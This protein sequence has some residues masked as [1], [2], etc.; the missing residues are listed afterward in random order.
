[1]L[2]AWCGNAQNASD[3]LQELFRRLA[4]SPS[5]MTRM[6]NAR[7]FLAVAARRIAVDFARRTATR[8]AYHAVAGA[9]TAADENPGPTD[10]AL[11]TAI[12][13]ALDN[14]PPEQRRVFQL[15]ILQGK[16]LEEIALLEKISLNTAASR[17]RY[18]LDKIRGPL[19]PY[20]DDLNRKD[21][22][23]MKN[24]PA[25]TEDIASQRIIT[26]LAPKRVPSV[27]PGLEG[28][29][30]MAPDACE[31]SPEIAVSEPEFVEASPAVE[32]VEPEIANCGVGGN[33]WEQAVPEVVELPAIDGEGSQSEAAE[34]SGE[35]FVTEEIPEMISCE[36]LPEGGIPEGWLR[37]ILVVES[38]EDL[39]TTLFE[40]ES[41]SGTEDGA[42]LAGEG[43]PVG[44]EAIPY[45]LESGFEICVL[46][47]PEDFSAKFDPNEVL[48]RYEEFLS[49]DP[50][51]L[52]GLAEGQGDWFHE[53]VT[54]ASAYFDKLEFGT[55]GEA[56]AFDHWFASNFG[57]ATDGTSEEGTDYGNEQPDYADGS[58][59]FDPKDLLV[60]YE[61]F[62]RENPDWGALAPDMME[63]QVVTPSSYFGELEFGTPSKAD[64]FDS[65][66]KIFYV[67]SNDGGDAD[68][69][70]TIMVTR[71]D[72]SEYGTI[73][74]DPNLGGGVG[75]PAEWLRGGTDQAGILYNTSGGLGAIPG[76]GL[77]LS[78]GVSQG[79]GVPTLGE[80]S[81]TV[82]TGGT[83][84][85]NEPVEQ[86]G[87]N[88]LTLS[89]GSKVVLEGGQVISNG[90]VYAFGPEVGS[91][92][93]VPDTEILAEVAGLPTEVAITD[94]SAEEAALSF[95][96]AAAGLAPTSG[97]ALIVEFGVLSPS[98]A[99]HAPQVSTLSRPTDD[100]PQAN[101]SSGG[102]TFA[103]INPEGL[104]AAQ[105]VSAP[106]DAL[107]HVTASAQQ[108]APAS[109]SGIK[110]DAP[111]A[112]AGAVAAGTVVHGGAA[113]PAIRRPLFKA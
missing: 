12:D 48:A 93:K 65:W 46:P 81:E 1:M 56:N 107:Q 85:T 112:T 111:T 104:S 52:P 67:K 17:L 108:S 87:D 27:A 55:P 2:T 86:V 88:T 35:V 90:N 98:E 14:V 36:I 33:A 78:G 50:T 76:T 82:V 24:D 113:A 92:N 61:G 110:I 91:D 63:I 6:K 29:A 62:L 23:L 3:M 58:W 39:L 75:I 49:Q 79:G 28:L 16:T 40:G 103:A 54:A 47:V 44:E 95:G 77:A 64:A 57:A 22:K 96:N 105:D 101:F 74:R 69:G 9:E 20:Y 37:P 70:G 83:L 31:A 72:G 94:T 21:F 26:P 43:E 13:L 71:P 15:K 41:E 89:N 109:S 7:A 32:L 8:S 10:A 18:A 66:L 34:E 30:A 99:T 102:S 5:V 84:V 53:Q 106:D 4:E 45:E 19:R 68:G 25:N 100:L 73:V 38:P 42:D 51:W 11:R 60:R 80:A 59:S 97:E